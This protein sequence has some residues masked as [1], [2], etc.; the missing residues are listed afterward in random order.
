MG[1]KVKPKGMKNGGKGMK[2]Q[3]AMVKGYRVAVERQV[4]GSRL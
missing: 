3:V 2:A 1:G 4:K